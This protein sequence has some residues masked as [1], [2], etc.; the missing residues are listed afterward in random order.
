MLR[1]PRHGINLLLRRLLL[2]RLP[3]QFL[4]VQGRFKGVA[5]GIL[6]A[7]SAHDGGLGLRWRYIRAKRRRRRVVDGDDDSAAVLVSL[8]I[9][10]AGCR[11][12][13][14]TSRRALR[15]YG[16]EPTMFLSAFASE[17]I[18]TPSLL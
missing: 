16:V 18:A 8:L 7:R 13:A 15:M 17:R 9:A 12:L 1:K 3:V 2:R 4:G 14:Y 6:S 11:G 5:D 10:P